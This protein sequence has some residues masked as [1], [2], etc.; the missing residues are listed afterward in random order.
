MENRIDGVGNFDLLKFLQAFCSTVDQGGRLA[1]TDCPLSEHLSRDL[2]CRFF[3][4]ENFRLSV[5]NEKTYYYLRTVVH[6][7]YCREKDFVLTEM[8]IVGEHFPAI[9]L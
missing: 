7:F 8:D 4:S 2:N 6:T 9:V 5:R 1:T 3:A